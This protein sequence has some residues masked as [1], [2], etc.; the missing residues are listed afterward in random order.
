M[1]GASLVRREGTKVWQRFTT[2]VDAGKVP[3]AEIAD[4]VCVL[5][6]GALLMTPGFLTD[7]VGLLL[8]FP[9]TRALARRVLVRRFTGRPPVVRATHIP[10]TGGRFGRGSV[11]DTTGR[12]TADVD[13]SGE[14]ANRAE[15]DGELTDGSDASDGSE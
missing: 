13:P 11:F 10:P 5:G 7:A 12:P 14:N 3:S 8:L 9:P 6:A 4:G 1:L 2:Q 15:V